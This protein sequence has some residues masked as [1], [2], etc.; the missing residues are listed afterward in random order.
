VTEGGTAGSKLKETYGIKR[1]YMDKVGTKV[2]GREHKGS[3]DYEGRER[4]WRFLNDLLYNLQKALTR[5]RETEKQK[6]LT[7]H[8]GG[9]VTNPGR[10]EA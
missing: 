8:R 6:D 2:G 10:G 4:G 3:A 7:L 1:A 5:G 9:T